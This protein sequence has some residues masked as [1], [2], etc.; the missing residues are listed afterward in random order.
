[1]TAAQ[2]PRPIITVYLIEDDRK[3]A[4]GIV[5][6]LASHPG[7]QV[8]GRAANLARA[9]QDLVRTPADVILFDLVLQKVD[10][11]REIT[12]FKKLV[13]HA[14][15][16]VLTAYEEVPRIFRALCAGA[17]GYLLKSDTQRPLAEALIEAW[18]FGTTFSPPVAHAIA[19]HF[20][21]LGE[22]NR[23]AGFDRLTAREETVL[24]H[25]GR[26]LTNKE[27]AQR[28]GS[29]PSTIR[30]HVE[31][32]CRKLGVRNRVQAAVLVQ[33][34]PSWLSRK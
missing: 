2:P 16:L 1:M 9:E 23:H 6:S 26:G 10:R 34:Q 12:R 4:L 5:E 24:Q 29:S 14:R 25:L 32:L 7:L 21:K 31:T 18:E 27:I 19:R 33:P 8:L 15:I 13:P 20:H 30:N 11:G 3:T 17:D 28:L 22:K